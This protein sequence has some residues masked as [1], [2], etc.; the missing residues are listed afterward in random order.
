MSQEDKKKLSGAQ[1]V[2]F[3]TLMR[4]AR[5]RL[6]A[7]SEIAADLASSMDLEDLTQLR[8]PLRDAI[9]GAVSLAALLTPGARRMT[10]D[11]RLRVAAAAWV[12]RG[13]YVGWPSDVEGWKH[14]GRAG[15]EALRWWARGC[16][17]GDGEWWTDDRVHALAATIRGIVEDMQEEA[18][19]G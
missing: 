6:W 17:P 11:G 13:K 2:R 14:D 12:S 3:D 5:S 7:A 1:L 15:L 16:S 18:Q 10:E 8:V 19:R 9:D 4:E